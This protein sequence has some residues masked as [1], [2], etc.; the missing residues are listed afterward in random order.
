M[1]L[2]IYFKQVF[3]IN[4]KNYDI[5]S[6][7]TPFE[8]YENLKPLIIRDFNLSS[9]ELVEISNR[10]R[11]QDNIKAEDGPTFNLNNT[12]TLESIL[13]NYITSL[14]FYIRPI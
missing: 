3:T 11:H 6:N 5:D 1:I 8:M 9:F 2:T 7:W 4:T 13:G 10:I 14:S 12:L